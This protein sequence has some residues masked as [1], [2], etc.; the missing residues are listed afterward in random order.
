VGVVNKRQM[1]TQALDQDVAAHLVFAIV[2]ASPPNACNPQQRLSATQSLDIVQQ[3][4]ALNYF[5]MKQNK[6]THK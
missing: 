2:A 1:A 3:Q 6:C 5:V 4:R